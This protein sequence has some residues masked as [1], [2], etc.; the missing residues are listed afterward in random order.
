MG[1]KFTEPTNYTW[2]C[3]HGRKLNEPCFQCD[4]QRARQVVGQWGDC[5]D[6]AR[7]LIAAGEIV[8]KKEETV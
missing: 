3:S 2:V 4:L 1:L 5:I 6:E 7:K 8:D